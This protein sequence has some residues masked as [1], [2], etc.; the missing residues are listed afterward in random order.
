MRRF[1]PGKTIRNWKTSMPKLFSQRSNRSLQLV[2]CVAIVI[3]FIAGSRLVSAQTD[4]ALPSVDSMLDRF[5][6]A[7]GG[8][9]ALENVTS[10]TFRGALTIPELKTTGKTTEYFK[11]PD[12][13]AFVAEIPGYGTVRTVCD[14]KTAWNVDPKAGV[15]E[16][17]GPEFSD[18]RRRA[19]IH[20]NLKLKEFYPGLKVTGRENVNGK[21]AWVLEATVDGWAYRLYFD[22][23]TGLLVRFDTDTHKPSGNTS[24]LIG[25]YRDVGKVRFA[26]AASMTSPNGGWSR[27]LDDVKFNVPIDDSVFARPSSTA[28]R[29]RWNGKTT[30]LKGRRSC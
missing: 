5:I 27:Q 6:E 16:I 28:G 22:S 10:E 4:S 8:R 13:F 19:D 30:G 20:W 12:Q 21:D 1:H 11:Y 26:F 3:V 7:L 14:G 9:A 24:V 29:W 15:S 17:S 18:I 23:A 2:K 25:D